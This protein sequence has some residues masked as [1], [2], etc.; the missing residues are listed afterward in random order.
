MHRLHDASA[1]AT[2]TTLRAAHTDLRTH[3]V[4]IRA[5]RLDHG[6]HWRGEF[7]KTCAGIHVAMQ[8]TSGPRNQQQN[9]GVESSFGVHAAIARKSLHRAGLSSKFFVESMDHAGQSTRRSLPPGGGTVTRMELMIGVKPDYKELHPF[10]CEVMVRAEPT[11]KAVPDRSMSTLFMGVS[12]GGVRVFNITTKKMSTCRYGDCKIRDRVFPCNPSPGEELKLKYDAYRGEYDGT[13][14]MDFELLLVVDGALAA[15]GQQGHQ[16]TPES[17]N[18]VRMIMEARGASARSGRTL[19][20]EFSD[21]AQLGRLDEELCEQLWAMLPGVGGVFSPPNTPYLRD[22]HDGGRMLLL[23]GFRGALL[24]SLRAVAWGLLND[25]AT[26]IFRG[27]QGAAAATHSVTYWGAVAVRYHDN[28]LLQTSA[29]IIDRSGRGICELT[30]T[31]L[32]D[33]FSIGELNRAVEVWHVAH[34]EDRGAFETWL[35][36]QLVEPRPPNIRGP[37]DAASERGVVAPGAALWSDEPSARAGDR[38]STGQSQRRL[39]YLPAS[40]S[41]AQEKA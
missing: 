29:A 26:T 22:L 23:P 13:D 8:Y 1:K 27:E 40:P 15:D 17:D 37:P 24:E 39:F 41:Q 36:A 11:S 14:A 12:S 4:G 34:R 16:S 6:S 20:Q 7:E 32:D 33:A 2:A 21:A 31:I 18:A 35:R 38:S 28:T 25:D 10:G 9:G 5:L 19:H 30:V 3:L